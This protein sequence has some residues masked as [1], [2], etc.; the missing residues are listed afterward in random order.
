MSQRPRG[1]RPV[2]EITE[3]QL[4]T[5]IEIHLFINRRG[6]PPTMKELAEVLE[7]SH[8]S[9]HG[10]VSQ[11]VRKDYLK[12]EPRKARGIVILLKSATKG[13]AI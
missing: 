7:I 3:P 8:A 10:Q 2:E 13:G 9:A 5:L 1:R 12:R 6:F 11:L 4:R